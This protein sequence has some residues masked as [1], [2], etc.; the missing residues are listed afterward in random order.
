MRTP[1]ATSGFVAEDHN[2]S[3]M[4]AVMILGLFWVKHIDGILVL[5]NTFFCR[6]QTENFFYMSF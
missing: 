6:V 2:H 4:E 3:T 1:G 5:V